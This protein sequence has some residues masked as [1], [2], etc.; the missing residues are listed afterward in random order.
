LSGKSTS[1]VTCH[2]PSCSARPHSTR[3]NPRMEEMQRPPR[4]A[5]VARDRI[6]G[7][8]GHHRPIQ[9]VSSWPRRWCVPQQLARP[10]SSWRPGRGIPSFYMPIYP[11]QFLPPLLLHG[12]SFEPVDLRC[13]AISS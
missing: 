10:I 3:W 11:L 8:V 6:G 13:P 1:M 2:L 4:R 7:V 9:L 5:C 12:R